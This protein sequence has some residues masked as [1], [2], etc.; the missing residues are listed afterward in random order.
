MYKIADSIMFIFGLSQISFKIIIRFLSFPDIVPIFRYVTEHEC[1]ERHVRSSF[2]W[3]LINVV[4][5]IEQIIKPHLNLVFF[6]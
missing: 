5:L 4:P 6:N 1:H 2:I 3:K